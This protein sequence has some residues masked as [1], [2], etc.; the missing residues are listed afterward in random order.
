MPPKAEQRVGATVYIWL[1]LACALGAAVALHWPGA[2]WLAT[3]FHRLLPSPEQ[4]DWEQRASRQTTAGFERQLLLMAQG[5]GAEDFLDQSLSRL[6]AA[7]YAQSGAL[8]QAERWTAVVAGLR[9]Y[10]AY[11]VDPRDLQQLEANP[12]AYL[13]GFRRLL[14]SPLGGPYL[15]SLPDDPLGLYRKFM[16]A[17]LPRPDRAQEVHFRMVPV[18]AERLG[19]NAVGGLYREYREIAALADER[20]VKFHATGAPLYTA[21]GV[22]SGQSEITNIGLA[23]LGLLLILMWI[24]LR[25]VAGIAL[26]LLT[27]ASAVGGGFVATLLLF[28][29]IH[30]LA[31]VFGITL[32][33]IAADY[34]FHYLSHSLLPGRHTAAGLGAVF[35]SLSL[36][37]ATSVIG[38][39]CLAL[40]PFP[41]LQQMGCFMAAG[42]LCGYLTVC[43]LF[44]ALYRGALR[45]GLPRVFARA[46]FA[47]TLPM[48]VWLV[49]VL[50]LGLSGVLQLEPRDDLRD[51]YSAPAGLRADQQ[52]IERAF[53]GTVDSS[54]LV[55]RAGTAE[56]LL[57]R[58]EQLVSAVPGLGGGITGLVPSNASQ[59]RALAVQRELL[60]SGALARWLESL[61]MSPEAIARYRERLLDPGAPLR[62][63]D[64]DALPVPR[65]G[66][67]FL[68]C[69]ASE[70]AS[71][72]RLEGNEDRD[73]LA[74]A[75]D[76]VEGVSLVQPVARINRVL[77][78]YRHNVPDIFALA[79][80]AI[81]VFL[82]LNLGWWA[83]LY[84]LALPLSACLV[85]MGIQGWLQGSYSIVNLLALLPVVGVGL[86]F[87]IFRRLAP[88]DG[89]AAV[90]L[91]VT[92]SACTSIL[93]FGMLAFSATPIIADFGLTIGTG[94]LVAW[95][96]CWLRRPREP[97]RAP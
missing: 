88:A 60:E 15:N 37:A 68:G 3:D 28:Q 85:A 83:A 24:A 44:P 82:A 43:L 6:S 81:F 62:V 75:I 77:A 79:T 73:S 9:P 89:A 86:D 66:G 92:L 30:L 23:S 78:D 91:A 49:P 94:L 96:L 63:E 1:V 14:F 38:F 17:N 61:G 19:F 42:L 39:A 25:S 10:A 21:F 18:P 34:A 67:G 55:V 51:F 2:G 11:L 29:Q 93:A 80:A 87:A 4:D 57:Q 84:V 56:Q 36:S 32:V 90:L 72:I 22:Q 58:E 20:G 69:E 52:A 76:R 35:R 54:Y 13:E 12:S 47:G 64:L 74:T 53:G 46:P 70:C 65:L 41:G 40:L 33:G 26:T 48:R 97:G 5:P 8:S 71:W 59:Q 27:V 31:L 50:L 7:R 16:A 95:L 45:T